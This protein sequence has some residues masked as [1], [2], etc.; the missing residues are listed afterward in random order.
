MINRIV[1]FIA[2]AL[3]GCANPR[4]TAVNTANSAADLLDEAN[5]E[6]A[7]REKRELDRCVKDAETK[8]QGVMCIEGVDAKYAGAWTAHAG[9]RAAVIALKAV[10]NIADAAGGDPD[11][12]ELAAALAKLAQAMKDFKALVDALT[13]E[14]AK[15]RPAPVTTPTPPK[16][17][18]NP[19]PKPEAPEPSPPASPPAPTSEPAEVPSG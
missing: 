19:P 4:T 2:V 13:E 3:L 1:Q 18:A 10:V 12:L 5:D 14:P 9:A 6:I 15:P 8:I 7:A 17:K 11:P 16:P